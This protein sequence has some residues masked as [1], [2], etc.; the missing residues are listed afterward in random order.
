VFKWASRSRT[1]VAIDHSIT[2]ASKGQQMRTTRTSLDSFR[3]AGE[4]S[5]GRLKGKIVTVGAALVAL[6]SA[7]PLVAAPQSSAS[8][9]PATMPAIANIDDRFE[10]YNVE[11]AEVIGGKFWKPYDAATLASLKAKAIAAKTGSSESLVIGQDPTMF[12]ARAPIDLSSPRLRRLASAL[13]P[14]YVRVSGTWANSAFFSDSDSP[15]AQAPAGF[16]GVLS[17]SQWKG[18]ID[19][20]QAAN[21]ELVTSFA[22]SAGVRDAAGVWTPRQAQPL[23]Q[24]TQSIGGKVAAA[25]LF[26]EPSMPSAGGAPPG[27]DANSYA[28]DIAAFHLFAKTAVPTM[29][30]VGPGSVGEGG[31]MSSVMPLLS[32]RKMLEA[33]PK[34][35]FDIYSY[36]S[37][38]AA[39]IRCASLGSSA[40]TTADVALSEEWLARPDSIYAFYIDL[41]DRFEPG[42]AVW[43]TETADA[44][45]GGNPWAATFLDGFRYLDQMGRLARRGVAVI[46]H[47]TLA[48]S[49]YGLL[50]QKSFEPRPNYWAALLWRRLMGT[51]VLDAAHSEAG[52]HLY[53]HCLR[54]HP[55]G[56]A[57]LAINTS[58]TQSR[59]ITLPM[60]GDRYSLTADTL[61]SPTVKLNGEALK[62]GPNDE[63]PAL[64]GAA[65][66]AGATT[67]QPVSID[68]LTFAAAHNANCH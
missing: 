24:Y 66:Q 60:A 21:A 55:G 39:S 12:Q 30:I 10:S 48:S 62:L 16:Q 31:V 27:Y 46:F 45:C 13:G 22:I 7:N 54:K 14:A 6:I 44:A 42:R 49:E 35:T 5:S 25:E 51:T 65:V 47:N 3:F 50:D 23:L 15:P 61:E 36:H 64:R 59:S 2:L 57:I 41:R 19:F 52:L 11:M 26:N 37:Y 56:V 9:S 67:L 33:S 8:I 53:A 28:K 58:R 34:P 17:R 68:F 63:L 1:T 20:T 4:P 38:A 40:Q 18:V 32:T 43:I 29:V